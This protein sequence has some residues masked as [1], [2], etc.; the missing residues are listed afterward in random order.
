LGRAIEIGRR[1]GTVWKHRE[2]IEGEIDRS[3]R[4]GDRNRD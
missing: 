3:I 2:M 1:E 4:E